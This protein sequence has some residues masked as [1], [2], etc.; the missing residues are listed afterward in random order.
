MQKIVLSEP[1]RTAIGIF[2][3]A[4]KDISAVSLGT[5][6][7]KEI[8]SRTSLP[9]EQ[10]DDCVMGNILGAG[11]GQNPARQVSINSGLKVETPAITVNRLCGSGLQSVVLAAQAIK[12]GD[13][14]CIVAGGMESMSTAPYY[15]RK[16][17]WGYKMS[18]P[19]DE[20]VD[21]ILCD[22]LMDAFNGYHMGVTAENLAEKY[23]ISRERQDEFAYSSQM[24]AK[25]AIEG[26]R[27]VS[28]IVPISVPGRK[29]N[30]IQFDV[31]EHPRPGVT[32]ERISELKPVF[33]KGGTVTA[34]NSSGINDGAAA[35]IVTSESKAEK[36]GLIPIASI[37]SYAVC[38]VDPSVMG[39][40]PVPAMRMALDR[41]DLCI[42]DINLVE[43]NEAFAAQ[44]LAVL[45]DFPIAQ[46]RLNVNGGS[47]ALGHPVGATGAVLLVKL[48]H[49][50]KNIHPGGYGMV[51]LCMGGGMGIAMI[52]EKM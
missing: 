14:E 16:A 25:V 18:A 31:D 22:G 43:L 52:V 17:R 49:E 38:G 36:L 50:F 24:K 41:A 37:K 35:L 34:A 47:I 23:G 30:S 40:G 6:V 29:G 19:S 42:D 48:L 33:K 5:E 45:S 44:S 4:L 2:G 32:L 15:L 9:P 28:Q 39:I 10:V 26:G 7:V 51:S 46:D 1:L 21:G 20:V 12:S 8:M 3:G 13:C 11:Q 27:F